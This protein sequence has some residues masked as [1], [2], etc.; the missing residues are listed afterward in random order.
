MYMFPCYSLSSYHSL[1]PS[2]CP[3][4]CSLLQIFL[5]SGLIEDRWNIISASVL[6]LLQYIV[7][8]EIFEEH[9]AS[10]KCVVGQYRHMLKIISENCGYSYM[11]SY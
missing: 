10:H 8:A 11:K 6:N 2:L 9:Q 1:L 4:V 7:L 3:Q 5:T